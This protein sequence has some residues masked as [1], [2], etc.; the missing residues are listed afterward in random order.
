M[1]TPRKQALSRDLRRLGQ[2]APTSPTHRLRLHQ[3]MSTSP[4]VSISRVI[5]NA[6]SLVGGTRVAVLGSHFPPSSRCFFGSEEATI[7][8]R[9]ESSLTCTSPPGRNLG[10]VSLTVGVG[11][12]TSGMDDAAE[13]SLFTYQDDL[14][15]ELW[16]ID[17]SLVRLPAF[18]IF[19]LPH[20]QCHRYHINRARTRRI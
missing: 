19:F 13:P 9:G 4:V 17:F 6:G 20:P 3:P 8:W 7:T 16:V 1:G 12:G 14:Y 18:L 11:S 2:A 5:P 15:K 10:P